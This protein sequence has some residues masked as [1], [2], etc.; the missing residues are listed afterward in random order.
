MSVLLIDNYDSFTF[1]LY[2]QIAGLGAEVRVVRNDQID[3]DG[4]REL[5]PTHI[6]LS[7]GPGHPERPR[8]FG[9]CSE[10]LGDMS[11]EVAILSFHSPLD[12]TRFGEDFYTIPL[13][14]DT[15]TGEASFRVFINPLVNFLWYGGLI[16]I[17]GAHLCVLPDSRERKRLDQALELEEA[18]V[19]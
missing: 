17:I 14:V 5:G 13:Y 1:N 16:F 15:R 12:G 18:A 7:P 10:V 11:T 6:V 8:D 19:A 4:I 3:L 2:Q 9:V